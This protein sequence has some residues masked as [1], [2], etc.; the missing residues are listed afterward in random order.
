MIKLFYSLQNSQSPS[1]LEGRVSQGRTSTLVV[2]L[3]F[4]FAG[5]TGTRLFSFVAVNA[6]KI[7]THTYFIRAQHC[8]ESVS[9]DRM[10]L[11]W[12]ARIKCVGRAV[13]S[14]FVRSSGIVA[15]TEHLLHG[16]ELAE[17]FAFFPLALYAVAKY[18]YWS[19]A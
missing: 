19:R 9:Q 6:R 2:S 7:N 11:M 3:V 16:Y 15:L 18:Y 12:R 8:H 1:C 10:A 14:R 5:I 13:P 17:E 4:L